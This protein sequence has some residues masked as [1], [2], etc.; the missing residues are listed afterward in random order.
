M[1]RGCLNVLNDTKLVLNEQEF[2]LSNFD[3]F[4]VI[5]NFQMLTIPNTNFLVWTFLATSYSKTALELLDFLK[6]PEV[7]LECYFL[8]FRVASNKWR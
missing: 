6:C 3:H 5:Q 2:P 7:L 1:N 8:S 4:G